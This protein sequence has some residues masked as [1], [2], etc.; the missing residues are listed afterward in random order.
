MHYETLLFTRNQRQDFTVFIRPSLLSNKD[1]STIGAVFNYVTDVAR[2][3]PDFPSLYAFPLGEYLLLLRHYN[4]GRKHAG[5]AIGVIEGIAVP[6]AESDDFTA[7]LAHFV[8]NQADLLDVSSTIPDIESAETIA[9][10]MHTW[11]GR[12]LDKLDDSFVGEFLARRQKDRL[13]L[14][15]TAEGRDLLIKALSDPLFTS[16]PFFAFGTNSDVVTQLEKQAA[17]DIASFFK[18]ERPSYRSR[19]TNGVSGSVAGFEPPE[20]PPPDPSMSLRPVVKDET[21]V[22]PPTAV[23][24]TRVRRIEPDGDDEEADKETMVGANAMPTIHT[25][26]ARHPKTGEGYDDEQNEDDTEVT[27]LTMRQLR[28][29]LR[30]DDRR[31]AEAAKATQSQPAPQPRDPVS[32]FIRMISSIFSPSKTKPK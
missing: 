15:F 28:N 18:T 23:E 3:K 14:P 19:R 5:R 24:T 9:S 32:R 1:V 20:A 7:S 21:R 27:M 22:R 2:L 13:F 6:K 10:T 12:P 11:D 26:T 4:S 17:V 29:K 25:L 8:S 16:P 30:E 31:A